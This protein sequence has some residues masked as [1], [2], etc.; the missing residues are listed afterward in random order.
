[1]HDIA[2]ERRRKITSTPIF[3][4]C[5]ITPRFSFVSFSKFTLDWNIHTHTR[6]DKTSKHQ[7]YNCYVYWNVIKV[8]KANFLMEISNGTPYTSH[9]WVDLYL[10]VHILDEIL[11]LLYCYS[12]QVNP[13]TQ[14]FIWE[15]FYC[16]SRPI[17]GVLGRYYGMMMMMMTMLLP[18]HDTILSNYYYSWVCVCVCVCQWRRIYRREM[19]K[20]GKSS[21][22]DRKHVCAMC[23]SIYKKITR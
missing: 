8:V 1:M 3:L 2:F 19:M 10:C 11:L 21:V 5:L 15:K 16:I 17:L 18:R 6:K 23:V 22:L 14:P 9:I 7:Y 13:Y 20:D 4:A 12:T